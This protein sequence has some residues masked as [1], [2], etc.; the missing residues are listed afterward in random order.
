MKDPCEIKKYY[1]NP[2]FYTA[3]GTLN[4]RAPS[5]IPRAADQFLLDSIQRGDFCYVLTSRQMGKSSLMVKTARQLSS[6]NISSVIIDLSGIGSIGITDEHWYRNQI[7]VICENFSLN[8][9][10]WWH[11]HEHLGV[12]QRFINFLKHVLLKEVDSRIAIFVD[13][14]DTTLGL[15]FSDDYFAAVRSIYN[16]RAYNDDIDRLNFVLLGAA[17]PIDLI[18]DPLKTPF[19]IGVPIQL[20]DFDFNHED[21]KILAH[22][23]APDEKSAEK[24]LRQ[25]FTWTGGHP[26]LTQKTCAAVA[27]WA[28]LQWNPTQVPLIVDEIV[29]NVFL[30]ESGKNSDDNLK[31]LRNRISKT[32]RSIEMLGYYKRI[33]ERG[34]IDDNEL[35]PTLTALKLSGLVK[36]NEDGILK[37][38]NRIYEIVFDISWIRS[39]IGKQES[40]E[41]SNSDLK[42]TQD[43]FVSYSHRDSRWVKEVL[44]PLLV[45]S[46]LRVKT[47]EDFPPGVPILSEIEK[48][49]IA[50]RYTLVVLTPS[51][52]ASNWI[53][54]ENFLTQPMDVESGQNGIIP[55]LLKPT[56]LPSRLAM[57]SGVDFTHTNDLQES[58]IL[59]LTALGASNI[60][61]NMPSNLELSAN[62]QSY[63]SRT[64][65]KLLD[66]A[67]DYDAL[68]TF[69]FDYFR[70][71]YNDL[72][73]DLS[74]ENVIQVLMDYAVNQRKL[75]QLL[76]AI[77]TNNPN[78]Y[79]ILERDLLKTFSTEFSPY[80][81]VSRSADDEQNDYG[82]EVCFVLENG[83]PIKIGD[84]SYS[85]VYMGR[86]R[87]GQNVAIKMLYDVGKTDSSDAARFFKQELSVT[88]RLRQSNMSKSHG[89][90]SLRNSHIVDVL[91]GNDKFHS[92]LAQ[93]SFRPIKEYF[94][95]VVQVRLSNYVLVMERYFY[96]LKDLLERIRWDQGK[97]GYEILKKL[98]HSL[99]AR[100]AVIILRGAAYGLIELH[101]IQD[102]SG[103]IDAFFHRDIKPGNI[104]IRENVTGDFDIALGDLGNLPNTPDSEHYAPG[105]L[106]YRS[107]EQ[108]Y[109][110]DIADACIV[111]LPQQELDSVH[112]ILE[113]DSLV[114]KNAEH[115]STV[116]VLII[117]DPK[118][119]NTLIESG[120]FVVFSK[121]AERKKYMIA[122]RIIDVDNSNYQ[123]DS[124]FAY[125]LHDDALQ[126]TEHMKT[127]VEFYKAQSYRTDLFAIG[128]VMFDIVT[129]GYSPEQFY[130]RIRRFETQSVESIV[131]DYDKFISGELEPE[132]L[133]FIEIFRPFRHHYDPL[134]PYPDKDIVEFILKCMLY[135]AEGTFFSEAP[136]PQAASQAL[137]DE[138]SVLRH[139][140]II[141]SVTKYH[142]NPDKSIIIH[143]VD[144]SHYEVHTDTAV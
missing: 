83:Q 6:E 126:I 101:N 18:K 30:S 2:D 140:Y 56:E 133:D 44:L 37:V 36:P 69:M 58:W 39:E 29:K 51:Y 47:D 21:S 144:V 35:D 32:D 122:K 25:V 137:Y 31:V 73:S 81:F 16:S 67:F 119:K 109:Y 82:E 50:S 48:A 94:S 79:R 38:R 106:H 100:E 5:Y 3:G 23:L 22:G 110:R 33:R 12:V 41:H 123:N 85:S 76:D 28:K 46:G 8:I 60:P 14:I 63:N 99:R 71:V 130:D 74:K 54:F 108:K 107:P 116:P 43:V 134:Q 7:Q 9:N 91:G 97:T 53:T 78:Q 27:R 26:Y 125:V 138:I 98:P 86:S 102:K 4:S 11:Q 131:K 55:L 117:T 84:G 104:F 19:N 129:G 88:T 89:E 139:K 42:F 120:D 141:E 13:E 121:D 105:T 112:K 34:I 10:N 59:L 1:P 87:S 57:I 49:V 62:Y 24:L 114:D 115:A 127:Q 96:S 65:R 77:A 92:V 70:P 52:M 90:A 124:R 68:L 15:S 45:S 66:T 20:T 113:Y 40:I 72:A 143:G 61:D 103:N 93:E 80:F 95:G 135:Q 128:A 142:I 64:I 75:E 136:E 17:S 118:F 132:N 111:R